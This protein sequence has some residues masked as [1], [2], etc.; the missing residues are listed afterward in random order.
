MILQIELSI[1]FHEIVNLYYINALYIFYRRK[2][3]FSTVS[4]IIILSHVQIHNIF[5]N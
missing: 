3:V 2:L 1:F 5:N 4:V